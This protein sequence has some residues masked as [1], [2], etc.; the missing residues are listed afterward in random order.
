MEALRTPPSE[1]E[2]APPS[3]PV[4]PQSYKELQEYEEDIRE[5][6]QQPKP[7]LKF[8]FA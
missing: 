7:K 5:V 6:R 3:P 8:G 4:K 2:Y 1:E